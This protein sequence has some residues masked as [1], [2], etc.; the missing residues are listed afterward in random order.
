[1]TQDDTAYVLGTFGTLL[2]DAG[3]SVTDVREHLEEAAFIADADD[4]VT[5]SVLPT[6]VLAGRGGT[7]P[8][9]LATTQ[10]DLSLQLAA[11]ANTLNRLLRRGSMGVADLPA[12]IA[13]IRAMTRPPSLMRWV[14]GSTLVGIGLAVLFRCDWWAILA[15]AVASVV[16]GGITG[17]MNRQP[18]AAAI[19]P[20][21][22]AFA[23]TLIVGGAAQGLHAGPVPL[24]ALCAPIAIL[25][26]GA[27]I[28]NA[29]LELTAQDIVTGSARLVYG[30]IVLAFM[31]AGIA[32]GATATG[33]RL[34][35][36]SAALVGEI[37]GVH[38]DLQGWGAVPPL[39]VSWFGVVLLAV[40]IA[41]AF[42]AG[43]RLGL[44]CIAAMI[45]AYALLVALTPLG[46]KVFATGAACALLFLLSRLV[47]SLIMAVPAAVSFQPA[48]LL[49]VPGTVGLVALAAAD[50]TAL[51]VALETLVSLCIGIKVGAL[52]ADGVAHL[53]RH[54]PRIP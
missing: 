19:V 8:A 45:C 44:L 5:F 26:P 20:F 2:L 46:G 21:V 39:W 6:L 54:L 9:I 50:E 43:A 36:A 3:M 17:L 33:L 37:A 16:V 48:F 28:T 53:R 47:G 27:L 11:R 52:L 40:G 23:S 4:V 14:S 24:F 41:L 15:A 42:G 13:E 25:V 32:A 30:M 29:L 51:T 34:D 1:M 22:V 7:E 38:S 35:P 49:L 10:G 31:S 18:R 12:R